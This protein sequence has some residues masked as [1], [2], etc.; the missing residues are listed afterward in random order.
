M[1][2]IDK[3]IKSL[4]VQD[5][6]CEVIRFVRWLLEVAQDPPPTEADPP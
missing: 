4:P 5:G 3:I 1:N 2:D 6:D